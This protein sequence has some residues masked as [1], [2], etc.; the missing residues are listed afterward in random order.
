LIFLNSSFYLFIVLQP[1]ERFIVWFNLT[2]TAIGNEAELGSFLLDWQR[3][4]ENC[5]T[6]RLVTT[7]LPITGIKISRALYSS[8]VDI[9]TS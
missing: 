5:S 6:S 9:L 3:Y 8:V 4:E 7:E 1:E 2:P